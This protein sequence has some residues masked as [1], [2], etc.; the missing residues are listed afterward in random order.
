MKLLDHIQ[1][2]KS[3]NANRSHKFHN[4][5]TT[6]RLHD[7]L[8]SLYKSVVEEYRLYKTTEKKIIIEKLLK[9]IW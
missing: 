9:I 1:A 3:K 2:Y 6:D 5:D 7:F 4:G 8:D